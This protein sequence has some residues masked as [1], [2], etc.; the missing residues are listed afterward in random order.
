MNKRSTEIL[1]AKP[2][3]PS[4]EQE[5]ADLGR[6]DVTQLREEL[7]K[8]LHVTAAHLRRLAVI[9]RL[10]E[11]RGEELADLRIGLLPY[12]RQIA[13]GQV[14]PE[15]I[16]RF[17][18]SPW[19]VRLIGGLPLPDQKRLSD[20]ERVKLSVRREDGFEHRLVDPLSMTRDQVLL[21]FS[22]D[23]LRTEEEQILILEERKPA[24][25]DAKPKGKIQVDR[26]AGGIRVGKI[27]ASPADLLAAI[28][29]LRDDAVDE[30][31]EDRPKA[32]PIHLSEAEHTRL[33]TRSAERGVA[34]AT[35]I[36]RAIRAAGLI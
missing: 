33:K 10:L 17:A 2:I 19:L 15:V 7:A 31:E 9:V 36:R 34:M 30:A 12:L 29:E 23:R 16:I 13:Y 11:E 35:L 21:A 24:R 26:K 28:A 27:L 3:P 4:L 32:V 22:R 14:L 6:L 1:E 18:E 8:S 20:G 5:Y 25:P